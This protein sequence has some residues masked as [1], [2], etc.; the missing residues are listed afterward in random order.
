MMIIRELVVAVTLIATA[1]SGV[2]AEE[3]RSVESTSMESNS[4][5]AMTTFATSPAVCPVRIDSAPLPGFVLSVA[6]DTR[7]VVIL[8]HVG[9]MTV[10]TIGDEGELEPAGV[11]SELGEMN[12]VTLSENVAVVVGEE[13]FQVIDLSDPMYP[14]PVGHRWWPA[15]HVAVS[16][17]LAFTNVLQRWAERLRVVDF[18]DPSNPVILSDQPI[19][20]A[21]GGEAVFV[22]DLD[23]YGH[24]VIVLAQTRPM[25]CDMFGEWWEGER[26]LIT[27]DVTDPATPR[28]LG[29]VNLGCWSNTSF[30]VNGPF[31]YT[32]DPG[33]YA[34]TLMRIVDVARPSAPRIAARDWIARD[35]WHIEGESGRLLAKKNLGNGRADVFVYDLRDPL[36]PVLAGFDE[37]GVDGLPGLAVVGDRA[38][39]GSGESG[40]VAMDL[41]GCPPR[42]VQPRQPM[43][44]V[45]P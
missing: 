40:L 3:H 37:G 22:E 14:A 15:S 18:S 7:R 20:D 17:S 5:E 25:I 31:V 38:Y 34:G 28:L 16:G 8:D 6:A 4:A 13:S 2:S 26:A 12:E 43:G 39:V 42:P 44:R 9:A 21:D 35:L 36:R 23:V 10:F 41:S 11:V 30:A 32:V 19:F 45:V 1:I 27:I 24:V 29:S 33:S